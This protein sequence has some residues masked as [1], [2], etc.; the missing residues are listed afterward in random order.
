MKAPLP[1][2]EKQRLAALRASNAI[3]ASESEHLRDLTAIAAQIT[4]APIAL[5]S[6]V[7]EDRQ[8]FRASVG[9]DLEGT[10]RD[11]SI[12]AHAIVSDEEVFVIDDLESDSRSS[13]NPMVTG[14][15]HLR[16]YAGAR[17][18]SVDG[19]PLG[20]LCVV[21]L[22]PRELTESQRDS[23]LN[24]ARAAS[25]EL[26]H[27][28][29]AH[30][31][32]ALNEIGRI[33]I[34]GTE[35]YAT[36][37]LVVDVVAVALEAELVTALELLPE[38]ST[39]QV[40][41]VTEKMLWARGRTCAIDDSSL[42]GY[43]VLKGESVVV[44]QRQAETLFGIPPEI[45][46][47]GVMSSVSV[48]IADESEVRGVLV[49]NS[50]TAERFSSEDVDFL[51][52]AANLI[53]QTLQKKRVEDMLLAAGVQ[54]R[55]LY[56]GNPLSTF[57]WKREG[58]D[59]V[60]IDFNHAALELTKGA[61]KEYVGAPASRYMANAPDLLSALSKVNAEHRISTLTRRHRLISTGEVRDL[62]FH[63]VFV[64][65][66]LINVFTN[67]ITDRLSA[68]QAAA[69]AAETHREF[70]E[71]SSEM[72]FDLDTAGK[73]RSLNPSFTVLTG[74]EPGEW[75]GKPFTDLIPLKYQAAAREGFER[76]ASGGKIHLDSVRLI[77]R[78]NRNLIVEL[79]AEP[80]VV[81]GTFTGIIGF[82]RDMTAQRSAEKALRENER[83]LEA[84]FENA[85][86]GIVEADQHLIRRVNRR[87]CEVLGY[88]RDELLQMNFAQ[89]THPDDSEASAE[90]LT[91]ILSGQTSKFEVE[92]RYRHKEGHYVWLQVAVSV[93][94]NEQGRIDG[95]I[96][97]SHDLTD[98]KIAEEARMELA[99]R[100]QL[101]LDSSS[102]GMYAIDDRGICTLANRAAAESLD[103]RVTDWIGKNVHELIHLNPDGQSADNCEI[104]AVATG[105]RGPVRLREDIFWSRDQTPVHVEYSVAPVVQ[106]S[107]C[108]GAVITF[109]DVTEK[110][111]LKK[112]LGQAERLTSLG[113]LSATVAH[114]FNN[115]LMGIQPFAEVI[116]KSAP[117]D[118]RLQRAANQISQS[119][120]RGKRITQEILRFTQ[121]SEPVR[122]PV[123]VGPWLVDLAPELRSLLS[124]DIQLDVLP[125]QDD[126]FVSIDPTQVQQ[127][128]TNLTM[129]ARDAMPSGGRLVITARANPPHSSFPFGVVANP[130]R[131][132]HFMIRDT[133]MGMGPDVVSHI[134]EPLFTTKRSG[135]GLGLS[136][137]HQIISLH[138][139]EVF[140]E[141]TPG[142]GTLFHMFLPAA[143]TPVIPAA[144]PEVAM[145]S[146]GQKILLVEDDEAVA[147]GLQ[148]NLE[149]E[150]I[151]VRIVGLGKE[152]VP[153]IEK[154]RPDLVICDIGL[155]DMNGAEVY[156]AIAAR[157]PDLPF[158]FSTGHGDE[159]RLEHYL[160][161]PHVGYLLKPYEFDELL[162]TI[163]QVTTKNRVS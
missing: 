94:R 7:E 84:I 134:F 157:W 149:M 53:A 160:K 51:Q 82:A 32:A 25:R 161:L 68:E 114:E 22:V 16:F 90:A 18:T 39:L 121:P 128:L 64:E 125:A 144:I 3:A 80:R 50:T 19:L 26:Q 133:G 56:M 119:V 123:E 36:V 118:E 95:F 24:L 163:E 101:I 67:D 9:T 110:N 96:G 105:V 17:I 21:D 142:K 122:K 70:V 98:R 129:N 52:S 99:Q 60:L 104:M 43:T 66:D 55:S 38:T 79:K 41:A 61:I 71:R 138:G 13:D 75:V 159:S 57:S 103:F 154:A 44:S 91:L 48:L 109:R 1:I 120:V 116:R 74:W 83:R 127:I 15:P 108:M 14:D 88:S 124:D 136:V 130:E 20:T 153:A 117:S 162:K 100:L 141:S 126:L 132:I 72:I 27:S 8:I 65:P 59:H 112:Q 46:A 155:P 131:F 4:G 30:R 11:V 28:T 23:L 40:C 93:M 49:V 47:M 158:I 152:A 106:A 111:Q 29:R 156:R 151:E 147:S 6:F 146:V 107:R 81:D 150:G 73:F 37:Q 12:C 54:Y 86:V 89:I 78:G 87:I 69:T 2:N 135:T 63:F 34:S 76:V 42:P 140:V 143:T 85:A 33:C 45:S 137:V 97:V 139:G 77:A 148:A 62:E 115:V 10:D 145:P 102:E 5:L 31:A 58:A 113:R 92:K 35:I